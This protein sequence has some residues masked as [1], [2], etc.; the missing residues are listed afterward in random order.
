SG[1]HL[2]H[3]GSVEKGP[4]PHALI[5][6]PLGY[7]QCALRQVLIVRHGPPEVL[8]LRE[9]PDPVPGHGEIR[10]AVS[11]SGVNF[12]D[13]LARLGLYPDAPKPPVVVGYEI[14]GVVDTVAPACP[15]L[16]VGHRVG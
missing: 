15:R 12:A 10:I 6:P 14:S 5:R 2:A 16:L 8:T 13:I 1:A 4:K 3:T 9:A 7:C 11:A